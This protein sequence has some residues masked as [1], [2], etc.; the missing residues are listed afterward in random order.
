MKKGQPLKRKTALSSRNNNLKRGKSLAKKS[1]K[2]LEGV[3]ARQ[4]E[5]RKMLEL[6]QLHWDTHPD[7]KCEVCDKQL[8]GENLT[9]YHEHLLDKGI[10]RYEHLKFE[11]DNLA[12]V[13]GTCH[14]CK[15]AGFP[16]PRHQELIEEAK[17]RFN[18]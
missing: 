18:V 3:E 8:Y 1:K 11:I 12:L 6:F 7:K 16:L 9:I 15:T 2:F 10:Q 13:C 14:A 17:I 4:E 5:G